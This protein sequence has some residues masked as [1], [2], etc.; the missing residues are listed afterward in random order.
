MYKLKLHVIYLIALIGWIIRLNL[1]Q[2]ILITTQ[3][4]KTNCN[5]ILNSKQTFFS[6]YFIFLTFQTKGIKNIKL[7]SNFHSIGE[8]KQFNKY[9]IV[10]TRPN[11]NEL[12]G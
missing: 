11:S 9:L 8:V 7:I 1:I 10:F 3:L 5:L 6:F 2:S 4:D 12:E